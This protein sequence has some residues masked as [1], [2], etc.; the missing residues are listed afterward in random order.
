MTLIKVDE[1]AKICNVKQQT[2]YA[3]IAKINKEMEEKGY[4]VIKG[5]VNKEYLLKR[6]GIGETK[7]DASN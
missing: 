2:A 3:L 5:R 1:V 6:F 4:L 7:E